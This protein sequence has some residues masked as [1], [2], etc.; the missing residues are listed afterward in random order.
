MEEH[1]EGGK[2]APGRRLRRELFAAFAF[3]ANYLRVWLAAS[4]VSYVAGMVTLLAM[5]ALRE[6]GDNASR[7]YFE[8]LARFEE[9]V[10]RASADARAFAL[11]GALGAIALAWTLIV[12]PD[13]SHPAPRLRMR[14]ALAVA[15]APALA[16]AGAVSLALDL[17]HRAAFGSA[18]AAAL[19]GYGIGAALAAVGGGYAIG[20]LLRALQRRL[21]PAAEPEAGS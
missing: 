2:R 12:R 13:V 4:F 6:P 15:L 3:L 9:P 10:A 5:I 1:P 11:Y 17:A 19:F 16:L 20:W 14:W 18:V 21:F 7:V 8:W